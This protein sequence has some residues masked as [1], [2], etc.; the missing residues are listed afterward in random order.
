M[1]EERLHD[2]RHL[3][4]PERRDDN[5]IVIPTHVDIDR[6]DGRIAVGIVG[7]GLYSIEQLGAQR[8]VV[9]LILQPF[10]GRCDFEHIGRED[11]VERLND[12]AAVARIAVI[13]HEGVALGS[14]IITIFDCRHL[15]HGV[16]IGRA[17]AEKHGRQGQEETS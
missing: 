17:G 11:S 16:G 15:G 10:L 14:G 6:V 5:H 7:V 13:N 1:E 12:I 8:I 3:A 9:G 2:G 4:P